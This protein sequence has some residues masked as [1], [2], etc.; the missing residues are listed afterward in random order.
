MEQALTVNCHPFPVIYT[1]SSQVSKGIR[2]LEGP[3]G[4]RVGLGCGQNNTP[5]Y[6]LVHSN[7]LQ[8]RVVTA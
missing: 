2:E 1:R 5:R 4:V 3:K 8:D 7:A 6:V